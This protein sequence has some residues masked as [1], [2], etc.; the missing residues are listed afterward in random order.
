VLALTGGEREACI[1]ELRCYSGYE[2][3][4]QTNIAW[5][6]EKLA[7]LGL[8]KEVR[9]IFEEFKAAAQGTKRKR[10]DNE[11][12]DEGDGGEERGATPSPSHATQRGCGHGRG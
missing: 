5:N 2:Q 6:K 8:V 9:G 10:G 11:E 4:R 12:D 1:S 3:M 7:E